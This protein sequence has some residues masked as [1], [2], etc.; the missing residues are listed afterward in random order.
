MSSKILNAQ[1]QTML[2]RGREIE[3]ALQNITLTKT[4]ENTTQALISDNGGEPSLP[5]LWVLPQDAAVQ[6]TSAPLR[7]YDIQIRNFFYL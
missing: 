5:P 3:A 4:V 2:D 7:F 6:G 1:L